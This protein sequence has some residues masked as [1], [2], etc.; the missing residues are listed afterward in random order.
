MSHGTKNVVLLPM[1][2]PKKSP[3]FN[4]GNLNYDITPGTTW[5]LEEKHQHMV[6]QNTF[7]F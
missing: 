7:F 2:E 5:N 1:F 3:K 6:A 4:F